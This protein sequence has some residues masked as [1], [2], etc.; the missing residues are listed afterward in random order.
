MAEESG[1]ISLRTDI[2]VAGSGLAGLTASLALA[3][4]GFE[5]VNAA[6]A[7]GGED[8]RT[9]A[10]LAA[11]VDFLAEIGVWEKLAPLAAPLAVM[12]IVDAT[13]R[14][15][16]APQVD[17]RAGE[18]GLEAFGYNV[19]NAATARVLRKA[20][21]E[22][23]V[24][25]VEEP[26]TGLAVENDGVTVM[27]GKDQGRIAA[28]LCVG[29]D[30]RNSAVRRLAGIGERSWRYRQTALVLN[31]RHTLP[32]NDTSTEFHG[33]NGPFTIVPLGERRSS[34]VWVEA[35]ETAE[36]VIG[37]DTETLALEV[38]RRMGSILGQ[39]T[40]DSDIQSFPL[41]GMVARE[42][43]RGPVVLVGEA[44]HVFPP[45][46]AQGFNLGVRDIELLVSMARMR[47]RDRLPTLG[48]D[49]HRRRQIDVASRGLSID[50][51][52][53]SLLS[54]FLPVQAA[55]SVG[56]FT[57]GMVGPLRRMVMREGVT[58]GGQLRGLGGR[59][60]AG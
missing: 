13:G 43:G 27:L 33:P 26:V 38:E 47:G 19:E 18:I 48:A 1:K 24:T 53:R 8:R 51:L 6:P 34:L 22:A 20:A 29:A 45:I 36:Q 3:R 39:V 31:F 9:T 12:R 10:L 23:G 49:F 16:R 17:F 21:G 11:S 46:G 52:N 32:H 37:Q 4:A 15:L 55:R 14:L 30:G 56:L 7:A 25:F 28:A 60:R 54:D 2:V 58:P 44:A 57:L 42:Y 41:S 5:V 40:I 59:R 35:P 50:L